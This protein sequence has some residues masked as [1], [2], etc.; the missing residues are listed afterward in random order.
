VPF[1][2][3]LELAEEIGPFGQVE[4]VELPPHDE[5]VVL[6]GVV[7]DGVQVPPALGLVAVAL[8]LVAFGAGMWLT[9]RVLSVW[10]ARAIMSNISRVYSE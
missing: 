4:R 3:A 1:L 2:H 9:T 7:G 8:R 10:N 5:L 6:L